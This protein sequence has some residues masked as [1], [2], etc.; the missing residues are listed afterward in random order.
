MKP[1]LHSPQSRGFALVVTLSLMI[2]LTI[3]AVGLLTLSSISLRASSQGNSTAETRANARLALMLALGDLQKHLGPDRAIT[4]PSEI[5]ATPTTSIAKPNTTG[6]WESWW[7]FNPN[8]A[9]DYGSENGSEK[10][11]RFRRWLVSSADMAAAGS[12]NF[13][14]TGWSGKSIELVGNGS[15]GAGATNAGKVTAGLVPVSKNGRIHGS[16][17][18]HV[19][20]ESVKARINLYRD[21]GQNSTLHKSGPCLQATALTPRS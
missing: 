7:D 11:S 17:A 6:V 9:P 8:G 3:I 14:T 4:A 1:Q 19:S 15:L 10:T 13:V 20:D 5:L 18:W 12:R 21:P 16:Y 2:L